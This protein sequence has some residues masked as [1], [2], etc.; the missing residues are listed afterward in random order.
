[1]PRSRK[2]SPESVGS[3]TANSVTIKVTRRIA[4]MGRVVPVGNLFRLVLEA[5]SRNASAS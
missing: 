1:L 2:Q 5:E 3:I 4:V